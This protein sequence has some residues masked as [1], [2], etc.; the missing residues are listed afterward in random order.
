LT[1]DPEGVKRVLEFFVRISYR[2]HVENSSLQPVAK[3]KNN[4]SRLTRVKMDS[5]ICVRHR[6]Q[7]LTI[8]PTETS[9]NGFFSDEAKA[10]NAGIR[11]KYK[12][13]FFYL[14]EA[15]EQAHKYLGKLEVNSE[16]LKGLVAA[17]LLSR[18]LTAYQGLILLAE[19]GFASEVRVICRSILEAKFKLGFLVEEPE[20]PK[21]MLA[22]YEGDRIKRLQKYKAKELPV[23][24]EAADHDWDKLITEGRARQKDLIGPKGGLPHISKIAERCGFQHDYFGPYAYFSDATHSGAAELEI[25]LEF[26]DERTAATSFRYGPDDGAWIPWCC[27]LVTGYLRD[28]IE[29]SAIIF[30]ANKDRR[31]HSWFKSRCKRH[32]EMLDRYR[33]QL[34]ADFKAAKH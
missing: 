9:D 31:F 27:L 10:I 32:K 16:D 5:I 20:A 7:P 8:M 28:C 14:A 3:G 2:G 21:M 22:K 1:V 25:Y 19:R 33:D 24:K 11:T 15:N 17:A 12:Q 13:L 23:H 4:C 30:G 34:S 6:A 18:T 26:N 29:I